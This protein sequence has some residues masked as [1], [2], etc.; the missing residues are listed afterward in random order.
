[1]IIRLSHI[2]LNQICCGITALRE[3]DL[4]SMIAEKLAGPCKIRPL[5]ENCPYQ[6]P[7][8][9]CLV[10]LMPERRGFDGR[11]CFE[12]ECGSRW[13]FDIRSWHSVAGKVSYG[14]LIEVPYDSFYA[15]VLCVLIELCAN[16][17][18]DPESWLFIV[19]LAGLP[20]ICC[21]AMSELPLKM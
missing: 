6:P 8:C 9:C 21:S 7:C 5:Q 16:Q 3:H 12:Q 20:A 10:Y 15:T 13:V 4:A 19:C 17:R 2:S 1:M 11:L 14:V 18:S